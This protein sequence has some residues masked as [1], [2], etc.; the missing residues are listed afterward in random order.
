MSNFLYKN[1]RTKYAITHPITVV[2][3][4]AT[5]RKEGASIRISSMRPSNATTTKKVMHVIYFMHFCILFSTI[6][7]SV[8][9]SLRNPEI[10]LLKAINE[11]AIET[12]HKINII[13]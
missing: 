1:K 6:S 13:A 12:A 8:I 3:G 11:I 5:K 4:N 2:A 7:F 9:Y 10:K